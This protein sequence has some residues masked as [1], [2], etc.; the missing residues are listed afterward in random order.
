MRKNPDPYQDRQPLC[1]DDDCTNKIKYQGRWHD[2]PRPTTVIGSGYFNLVLRVASPLAK[3][4]FVRNLKPRPPLPFLTPQ[5]SISETSPKSQDLQ[6]RSS[7]VASGLHRASERRPRSMVA[8]RRSLLPPIH[9]LLQ[10]PCISRCGF[11]PDL[12]REV[13]SRYL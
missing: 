3:N 13:E 12:A 1:H 7:T 5:G 4:S 9:P 6:W 2:W 11:D 10:L 8:F